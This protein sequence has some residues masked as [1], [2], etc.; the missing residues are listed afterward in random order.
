MSV[1]P[2]PVDSHPEDHPE[3]LN[4]HPQLSFADI[5]YDLCKQFFNQTQSREAGVEE[6][7]LLVEQNKVLKMIQADVNKRNKAHASTDFDD[8]ASLS[9]TSL[10]Q[11]PSLALPFRRTSDYSSFWEYKQD[12]QSTSTTLDDDMKLRRTSSINKVIP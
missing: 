5:Q 7:R 6:I 11:R 10:T 8:S 1:R 4:N 12:R 9:I 3:L 2:S